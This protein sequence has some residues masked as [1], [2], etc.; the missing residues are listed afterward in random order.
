MGTFCQK[1]KTIRGHHAR[2]G[3]KLCGDRPKLV[4]GAV[5]RKMKAFPQA[6]HP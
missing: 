1:C 5:V 3:D 6:A 2:F 4:I